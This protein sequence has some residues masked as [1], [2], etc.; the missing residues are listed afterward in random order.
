MGDDSLRHAAQQQARQAG[1]SVRAHDNDIGSPFC[2]LV[3]DHRSGIARSN[4]GINR[5]AGLRQSLGS[6]GGDL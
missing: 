5:K 6:A 4:G 1:V 3:D 2:R